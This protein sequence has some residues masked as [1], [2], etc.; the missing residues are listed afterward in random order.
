[1]NYKLAICHFW[2][3]SLFD[4]KKYRDSV[5]Q[6]YTGCSRKVLFF[7]QSTATQSSSI[8]IAARDL[9]SSQRNASVQSFQFAG[10][11]MNV[12]KQPRA[13][14]DVAAK[15]WQF[16]EKNTLFL[17]HSVEKRIIFR[18][19]LVR[20]P[21]TTAASSQVLSGQTS[22]PTSNVS[23]NLHRRPLLLAAFMTIVATAAAA[24]SLPPAPCRPTS[25]PRPTPAAAGAAGCGPATGRGARTR[26]SW[27]KRWRPGST[28]TLCWQGF[29]GNY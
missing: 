15:Y 17:E 13:S 7:F 19:D 27:T 1:M 28:G 16:L 23:T 24:P 25:R 2:N 5:C 3:L 8:Y 11:F 10:H 20:Y 6:R 29:S 26:S 9:Q 4:C 21:E 14:E 18:R 12:Q 22:P